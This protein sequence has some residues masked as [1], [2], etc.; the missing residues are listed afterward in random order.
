MQT[1]DI[2][3]AFLKQNQIDFGCILLS[4]LSDEVWFF[5][6]FISAVN[7][8]YYHSYDD[9]APANTSVRVM[10]VEEADCRAV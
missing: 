2:I 5:F 6:C 7:T 4:Y 3:N 10:T 9:S 8:H 1:K